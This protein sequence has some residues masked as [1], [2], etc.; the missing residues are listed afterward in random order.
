MNNA[1]CAEI[2]VLLPIVIH[3]YTTEIAHKSAIQ[4]A[5]SNVDIIALKHEKESKSN[6]EASKISLP[7]DSSS[8]SNQSGR[9]VSALKDALPTTISKPVSTTGKN[10]QVILDEMQYAAESSMPNTATPQEV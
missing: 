5:L 2:K 4:R 10:L 3:S 1:L 7:S 9:L 6:V 8:T